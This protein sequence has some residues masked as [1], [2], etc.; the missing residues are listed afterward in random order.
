VTNLSEL[1]PSGGGAKEFEAVASGTLP[2]GQA[3]IMRSD[4]KVEAVGPSGGGVSLGTAKEFDQG[5][6]FY[7]ASFYDTNTDQTAIFY[8]DD[9]TNTYYGTAC[10]AKISGTTMTVGT[11]QVFSTATTYFITCAFDERTTGSTGTGIVAYRGTSNYGYCKAAYIA[12]SG[13]IQFGGS[14]TFW[15]S[16]LNGSCNACWAPD[17]NCFVIGYGASNNEGRCRVVYPTS[18][19][20]IT[21]GGDN[22][23]IASNVRG[24][25][26]APGNQDSAS[27]CNVIV[28][29]RD[30]GDSYKRKA[31]IGQTLNTTISFSGSTY[32]WDSTYGTEPARVASVD[33]ANGKVVVAYTPSD[34]GAN[35]IGRCLV[36]TVSGNTISFGSPVNFTL[37]QESY[38]IWVAPTGTTNEF[39]LTFADGSYSG[40]P[41]TAIIG[42]VSGTTPS[43]SGIGGGGTGTVYIFSGSAQF[44]RSTYDSDANAMII[45]YS[46]GNRTNDPN[47]VRP[48]FMDSSNSANFIGITSEAIANSATGKVNPQGGV[49]TSQVTSPSA[50]VGVEAVFETAISLSA[51]S[52]FDSTNNRI[53]VAYMD[54]G[55]SNYG[56]AV[57]GRIN[58]STISFGTPVPFVNASIGNL[59]YNPAITFD[60]NAG[61]AIIAFAD[62]SNN[63]YWTAVVATVNPSDDSITYGAFEVI[64]S[65]AAATHIAIGFDTSSNKC[66]VIYGDSSNSNYTTGRVGTVS[67]TDITFGT[68][69]AVI[70]G[71]GGNTSVAFDSNVNKFAVFY[72]DPASPYYGKCKVATISGTTVTYGSEGQYAAAVAAIPQSTFDSTANKIVVAFEDQSNSNYSSASVGTISGTN[73]TFGSSSVILNGVPQSYFNHSIV[74]DS[75]QNKSMYFLRDAIDGDTGKI[76]TGTVSGTT[77]TFVFEINFNADADVANVTATYDSTAQKIGLMYTDA[78]NSNYGTGVVYIPSGATAPFVIGSTYYVQN[79]G[80]LSTTSSTVT[81]G[82][83]IS[84]T[85]LILNGAS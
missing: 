75:N 38:H 72:K 12:S 80:N 57:V 62:G 69:N 18:L 76:Y 4:G 3:V 26:V 48:F 2:N 15:S 54:Q 55:N 37:N 10:S 60:S 44:T 46:D 36:A 68:K 61:K 17:A 6:N 58:G 52:T 85:Q 16:T 40:G 30:A 7:Y 45:S 59:V 81:A 65:A 73:I 74:Y 25:N 35:S 70:N 47:E 51:V 63:N 11:P 71:N 64:E 83:A 27:S 41:G 34:T 13:A 56:T 20:N 31:R 50:E 23:F 43:Y 67:G 79:D 77:I 49:A 8:T 5:N 28:V 53:I 33:Y 78:D 14:N 32:T 42:T 19:G 22:A 66:L 39:L 24:V 9:T 21:L 84:T 1:L 82:K 29:F